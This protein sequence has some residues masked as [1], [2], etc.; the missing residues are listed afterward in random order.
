[1]FP[2]QLIPLRILSRIRPA[3]NKRHGDSGQAHGK[4]HGETGC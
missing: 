4:G 1:M 2:E 3:K